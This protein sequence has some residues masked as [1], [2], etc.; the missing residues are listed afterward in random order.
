MKKL[1]ALVLALSLCALTLAGCSGSGS[2]SLS[3]WEY[4]Q[5]K[6]TLTIG[7]TYFE[8]MNYFDGDG[9]LVGFET[10]FA[11]AVC[12]ELGVEPVFQEI[13]W[14]QKE[15]ELKSRNIDCIWNGLTITDERKENMAFSTPYVN[16][17]QAV[18]IR[19]ADA[20]KYTDLA[21]LSGAKLC[22]ENGSAG[23][24][25]IQGD[26]NLSGAAY[27]AM[28]AQKSALLEVKAG[29]SDAAVI[30]VVYANAVVKDDTDY[31]DLMIMD[32]E[33]AQELYGIGLRLED[34][35]TLEKINAA[36]EKVKAD[37]TLDALA[38]KYGVN[39][40]D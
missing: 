34:T 32:V 30:D 22:A 10:E 15:T 28:D 18:V 31:S 3:D 39:L 25:A 20:D 14:E 40:C 24:E 27:T 7:I 26:E 21:S 9:K 16:N 1:V 12:A 19:K 35:E 36:I 8:P 38:E 5:D 6:G 23:E 13:E 4:I 17:Y 2:N 29:A 11:E 33:L 37:G